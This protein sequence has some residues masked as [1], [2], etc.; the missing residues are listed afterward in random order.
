MTLKHR[1]KK[2]VRR[3]DPQDL[4]MLIEM[5]FRETAVVTLDTCYDPGLLSIDIAHFDDLGPFFTDLSSTELITYPARVFA[6]AVEQECSK[7]DCALLIH[8]RR[9]YR[10]SYTALQAYIARIGLLDKRAEPR[11]VAVGEV[12]A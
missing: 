6:D 11:A 12:K 4:A 3:V 10:A 5:S 9:V 1:Y 7:P 8:M 2:G